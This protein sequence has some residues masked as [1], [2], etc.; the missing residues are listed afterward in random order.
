MIFILLSFVA[1]LTS[2]RKATPEMTTA[3][4]ERQLTKLDSL[5]L[6][7][8]DSLI[9]TYDLSCDS[10]FSFPDLSNYMIQTL[11]LSGNFLDTIII[12]FMPRRIEKINLSNN[13]LKDWLILKDIPSLTE[14]NLSHNAL[15]RVDIHLKLR[16]LILSYNDLEIIHFNHTAMQYVDVSYNTSLGKEVEFE[17]TMIDT[18]ISEGVAGGQHLLGPISSGFGVPIE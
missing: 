1:L 13:K 18:V 12:E 6:L 15:R 17:P 9:D 5:Y 8:P 14:L 3:V 2:C 4:K 16:R 10:I 7:P 11:D